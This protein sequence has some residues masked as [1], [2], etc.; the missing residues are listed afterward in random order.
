MIP[1]TD[2]NVDV[3]DALLR[4]SAARAAGNPQ[5]PVAGR[6]SMA[7]LEIK[8]NLDLPPWAVEEELR[9][10]FLTHTER[11]LLALD[12]DGLTTSLRRGGATAA[13]RW[14]LT[15]AQAAIDPSTDQPV[16][17]R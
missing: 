3:D 17:E 5:D 11:D 14:A 7:W 9:R 1:T 15:L 8:A 13:S 16:D 4:W 12:V 6:V 2:W 10:R